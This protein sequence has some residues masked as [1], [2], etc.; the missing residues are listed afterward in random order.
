LRINPPGHVLFFI[1]TQTITMQ[2]ASGN[3]DYT[4]WM[5][6]DDGRGPGDN[7]FGDEKHA[8]ISEGET[9]HKGEEIV[10]FRETAGDHL[11]VDRL[12]YNFRHPT[13]GEIIVFETRGIG[14][15]YFHLPPDQFYIKRMVAMGG[16]NVQI[17]NDRHLV[18]DGHRLDQS[19]PHFEK[20]YSFDPNVPAHDSHYSGHINQDVARECGLGM[21]N[22]APLFP[23]QD[24][25]YQIQPDH[26]MVMGDNTANSFDSRAWGEFS[27]TN[28]IGKYFFV[29]WPFTE[30]FGWNVK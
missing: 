29:Y 25:V 2:Y 26:Y 3:K 13:H 20:V 10:N 12:T 9:F 1:H 24:T 5:T 11:F 19:T 21:Y 22:I 15:S 7:R 8:G 27:R 17:G 18:I 16:E 6:P 28:V 23:T 4:F 14:N 30:R